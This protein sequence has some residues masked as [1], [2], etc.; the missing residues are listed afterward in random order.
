MVAIVIIA[1]VIA[2]AN[3]EMRD[4]ETERQESSYRSAE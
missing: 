1:I 2:F 3:Q 4:A